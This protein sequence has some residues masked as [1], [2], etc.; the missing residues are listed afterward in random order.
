MYLE[1]DGV[2]AIAGLLEAESGRA[3]RIREA[4]EWMANVFDGRGTDSREEE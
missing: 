2:P 3:A 4:H 1:R